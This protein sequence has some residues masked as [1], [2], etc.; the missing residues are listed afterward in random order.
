MDLPLKRGTKCTKQAKIDS[1]KPAQPTSPAFISLAK[2]LLTYQ[3]GEKRF[4]EH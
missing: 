1:F 3:S 4:I 2:I